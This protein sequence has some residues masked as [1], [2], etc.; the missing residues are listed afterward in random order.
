MFFGSQYRVA[1][2]LSLHSVCLMP[3]CWHHVIFYLMLHASL[4]VPCRYCPFLLIFFFIKCFTL[5]YS[6]STVRTPIL[7]RV[8]F[9]DSCLFGWV[10]IPILSN[11]FRQSSSHLVNISIII[12]H[13][14]RVIIVLWILY[15]A[16][17]EHF[18][19][20]VVLR[21]T[22]LYD[23]PSPV[24]FDISDL[25]TYSFLLFVAHRAPSF[26]AMMWNSLIFNFSCEV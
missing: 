15:L 10:S 22:Y 8:L 7:W 11:T 16:C 21:L 2:T 14:H 24:R 18:G 1:S 20:F 23:W 17:L 5:L 3:R 6:P 4:M 12:L 13:A 25:C 19:H 9:I 26:I